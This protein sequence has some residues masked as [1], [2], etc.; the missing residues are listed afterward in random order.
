LER[1]ARDLQSDP[2]WARARTERRAYRLA[3]ACGTLPVSTTRVAEA[4]VTATGDAWSVN[5]APIERERVLR[6]WTPVHLAKV[7][8]VDPRTVR[9]L[10]ASRRRPSLGTVQALC[11]VLGLRLADVIVFSE[12]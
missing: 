1:R 3:W 12:R 10:V 7:A 4:S 8:H 9:S 5:A 11:T 2:E 6:G